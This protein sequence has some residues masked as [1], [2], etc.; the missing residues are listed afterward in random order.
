MNIMISKCS[1]LSV[2]VVGLTDLLLNGHVKKARC[3]Y[4]N[5]GVPKRQRVEDDAR[6]PAQTWEAVEVAGRGFLCQSP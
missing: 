1:H 4:N 5:A 2:S 6:T 3:S